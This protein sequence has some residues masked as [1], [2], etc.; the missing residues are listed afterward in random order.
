MRLLA[1]I[2]LF[3]VLF[4]ACNKDKFTTE[5]QITFKSLQPNFSTNNTARGNPPKVVFEVRDGNGD[6]DTDTAKIHI[7]NTFTN[8]SDSFNF[9]DLKP[10]LGKDFRSD[11]TVNLFDVLGGRNPN[12]VPKPFTD[13][14][15]FEIFVT[16]KAR[17][18]SNVIVTPQFYY[19]FE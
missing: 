14:I 9:P 17:N 13:T 18:K 12:G 5:P 2:F 11:V 15:A 1:C 8:K 6:L 3:A 4:S 16:D 7:K 10:I 19:T